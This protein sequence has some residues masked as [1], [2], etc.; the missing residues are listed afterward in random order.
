MRISKCLLANARREDGFLVAYLAILGAVSLVIASLTGYIAQNMSVCRHR[1]EMVIA[2]HYS[3]SG[4]AMACYDLQQAYKDISNGSTSNLVSR[5]CSNSPTA[6]STNK[7]LTTSSQFVC[8]RT[9]SNLFG[10][11]PITVQLLI[12]NTVIASKVQ[13]VSTAK[14]GLSSQTVQPMVSA[15]FSAGAA[16]LSCAPG[17][18]DTST[19]K[20]TA[21][22]GD[23]CLNGDNAYNTPPGTY[24]PTTIDG[25]VLANGAVNKHAATVDVVQQHL[26]GTPDQLADYTTQNGSPNQLFDFG[27]FIAVADATLGIK[28]D[29][30]SA[31]KS[32]HFSNIG[33]FIT[34]MNKEGAN[35]LEGIVVIDIATSDKSLTYLTPTK[36][37]K[38]INIRGTLVF[39]FL[40]GWKSTDKIVNT[41][42]MN[43]NPANL[44]ALNIYD[45]T[46]FTS[47]YSPGSLPKY[48]DSSKQ[49]W[50][51]TPASP[52]AKFSKSDALPALM[53]NNAILDIHGGCNI[54]GVVYSPCFM[55]IENHGSLQYFKGMLIGGGGIFID[56]NGVAKGNVVSYDPNCV[57]NL[58]TAGNKA[59]A[60]MVDYWQR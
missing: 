19:S 52:Y 15:Q 16:I 17:T 22:L 2:F 55:E 53:Y 25:A 59:K 57:K 4:A 31:G 9:I 60:V 36:M 33:K 13:V 7:T 51:V 34:A 42:T 20:A 44:A 41:A 43:I 58:A 26:N 40:S 30:T 18:S 35:A 54:S 24:G 47:G 50:N 28:G 56:N 11:Q 39:N 32:N 49:P 3:E 45:P 27:R 14:V 38:G 48:D 29:S 12:S 5:L 21:K 23:V 46:T 6:Y 37:P 10:S 1:Q 8:Q